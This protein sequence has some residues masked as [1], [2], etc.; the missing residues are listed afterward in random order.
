MLFED[1]EFEC[2]YEPKF[3]E[4]TKLGDILQIN[5][6]DNIGCPICG[7]NNLH[8]HKVGVAP[9]GD[10]YTNDLLEAIG[11]DLTT[12]RCDRVIT[13]YRCEHCT[14]LNEGHASIKDVIVRIEVVHKG[15]L[16]SGIYYVPSLRTH[17]L[18]LMGV[19]E[20]D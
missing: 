6:Y 12:R 14:N 1:D 8:I 10:V 4:V 9:F 18:R 19:L 15:N 7:E 2:K 13:I 16:C 5:E 3:D 20:L 17:N 11:D